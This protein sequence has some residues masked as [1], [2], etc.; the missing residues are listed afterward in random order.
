[1]QENRDNVITLES[2]EEY[3]KKKITPTDLF[4]IEDEEL[5]FEIFTLGLK[6]RG[7]LSKEDFNST[8]KKKKKNEKITVKEENKENIIWD[9]NILYNSTNDF[10]YIINYH[11]HFC[12]ENRISTILFIR[13]LNKSK[14]EISSYID[15]NNNKVIE[16]IKNKKYIYA[17]KKD[18]SYYNWK[19]NYI[20]TNSNENYEIIINKK[21]GLIFKHKNSEKYFMLNSSKDLKIKLCD[22]IYKDNINTYFGENEEII[23][24]CDDIKKT[25]IKDSNYLQ[26]L[27][28]TLP[29]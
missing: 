28:Y 2:Y 16:K 8:Y 9:I 7:I 5:L 20:S 21:I 23:K 18:L 13:Y 12:K 10:F 24:L 3:I 1:M 29:L 17:S 19:N 4:Y 25:E 22:N 11:I 6:S 15:I 14:S 26:C 27:L